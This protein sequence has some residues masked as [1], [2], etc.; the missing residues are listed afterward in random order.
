MIRVLVEVER[1][2]NSA[3]ED[4]NK[5]FWKTFGKYFTEKLFTQQKKEYTIDFVKRTKQRRDEKHDRKTKR[6]INMVRVY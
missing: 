2:I 6:G 1:N 3:A 5:I 4:K